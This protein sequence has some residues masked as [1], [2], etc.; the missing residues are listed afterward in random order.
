MYFIIKS[1]KIYK[2]NIYFVKIL[3]LIVNFLI[4]KNIK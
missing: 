1:H 2:I 3:K 4:F